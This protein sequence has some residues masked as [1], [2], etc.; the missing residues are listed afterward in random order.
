[1][2][3]VGLV[4]VGQKERREAGLVLALVEAAAEFLTAR[5]QHLCLEALR[6]TQ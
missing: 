2:V 1:L 3:V 4:E 5:L 6:I